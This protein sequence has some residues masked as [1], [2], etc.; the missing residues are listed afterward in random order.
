MGRIRD[1]LPLTRTR[2]VQTNPI[3]HEPDSI[4][5]SIKNAP[6]SAV[7]I[8]SAYFLLHRPRPPIQHWCLRALHICLCRWNSIVRYSSSHSLI[9]LFIPSVIYPYPLA[10]VNEWNT[11]M[12][13]YVYLYECIYSSMHIFIIWPAV[14]LFS[15]AILTKFLVWNHPIMVQHGFRML[16]SF[17]LLGN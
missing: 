12:Y 1:R 13:V 17:T 9:H 2:N 3:L 16:F 8:F 5:L 6:F 14:H 4:C 15:F 11:P 10:Y 7:N